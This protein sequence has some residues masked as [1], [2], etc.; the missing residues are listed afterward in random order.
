VE[1]RWRGTARLL[2]GWRSGGEPLEG[3]R[4]G[5]VEGRRGGAVEGRT[6]RTPVKAAASEPGIV[7]ACDSIWEEK[8]GR[9][10]WVPLVRC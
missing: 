6:R 8:Q 1:G 7:L 5:A 4:G 9:G 2:E 3:R 10:E